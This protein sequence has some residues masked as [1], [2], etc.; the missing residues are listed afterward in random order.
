L[1]IGVRGYILKGVAGLEL[2]AALKTIHAGQPFVTAELAS[3][4]LMD[5]KGGPLLPV[6]SPELHAA[7]SSREQQVLARISKGRTNREIAEELGVTV[8]TIKYYLTQVFKKLKV[9]NRIQAIQVSQKL[10]CQ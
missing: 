9:A 2:I 5:A 1:A 7:L 6:R 10:N 4:L 8:K 3:R